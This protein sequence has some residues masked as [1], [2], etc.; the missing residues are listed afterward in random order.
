MLGE[1][2]FNTESKD[3]GDVRFRCWRLGGGR[4]VSTRQFYNIQRP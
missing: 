3:A 1:P 4:L 2:D